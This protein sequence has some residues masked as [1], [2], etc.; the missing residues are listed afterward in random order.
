MAIGNETKSRLESLGDRV[1]EMKIET[2]KAQTKNVNAQKKPCQD[3]SVWVS[4]KYSS[5]RNMELGN[6]IQQRQEVKDISVEEMLESEKGEVILSLSGQSKLVTLADDGELKDFIDFSPYISRPLLLTK[7]GKIVVGIC[8][9]ITYKLSEHSVR[10]IIIIEDKLK[11]DLAFHSTCEKELSDRTKSNRCFYEN[12]TKTIL[13]QEERFRKAIENETKSRLKILGDR[14]K[15]MNMATIKAQ[16]TNV[17]AQ[18]EVG[19]NLESVNL[20]IDTGSL[21]SV[22]ATEQSVKSW[23]EPEKTY[24]VIDINPIELNCGSI[25]QTQISEMFGSLEEVSDT[26]QFKVLYSY[27]SKAIFNNIQ[28]CQDGSVW[29]SDKYSCLRNIELGNEIQQRQEVKRI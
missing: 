26:V 29:V 10:Q 15:E 1:N 24:R 3:G 28:P 6:K 19:S 21:K 9:E 11:E 25:D 13:E 8:K 2:I 12:V 22:I 7:S 23:T 20:A 16:N 14:F 4:N 27:R 5:L 17:N 18:K